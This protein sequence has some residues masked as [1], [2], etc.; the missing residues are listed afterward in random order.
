[1]I[2]PVLGLFPPTRP[3]ACGRGQFVSGGWVAIVR[4]RGSRSFACHFRAAGVGRMPDAQRSGTVLHK[5]RAFL[6][7]RGRESA[8]GALRTKPV[9]VPD[10]PLRGRTMDLSYGPKYED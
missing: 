10:F 5:R 3:A 4:P 6:A 9:P 2:P 8:R 1:M 7:D